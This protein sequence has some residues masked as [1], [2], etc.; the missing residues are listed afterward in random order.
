MQKLLGQSNEVAGWT[1]FFMLT[2]WVLFVEKYILV[3]P[4]LEMHYYMYDV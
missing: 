1:S 3:I 4:K 2:F